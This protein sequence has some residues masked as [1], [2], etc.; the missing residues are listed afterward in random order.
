MPS[1]FRTT[2][3]NP[4]FFR[5]IK[6]FINLMKDEL[7][8]GKP[9]KSRFS[10]VLDETRYL[11]FE[12]VSKLRESCE[13]A[14]GSALKKKQIIPVR[15]WF[16][17]ELGLFTGL[18][19][20]EMVNLQ[21]ADLHIQEEQSSLTVQAGKGDKPRTVYFSEAFKHECLFYLE[22]KE[23]HIPGIYLFANR[24]GKQLSKRTLQ[25]SFKK[26]LGL[27]GLESHYSIH[28]LRHTY[29]SHLYKASGHN[30]RLVQE[31]LGHSSIRTTQIYASLMDEEVK[32]SLEELYRE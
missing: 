19:V 13:K 5:R 30:L 24:E 6:K 1:K 26:C 32:K 17:V 3:H 9:K 21:S 16:M 11:N 2:P 15:N 20:C 28:S 18:R 22:W 12:K 10:W 7:F 25:K 31:Q 8:P 23:K 29:G 4:T 27:A 14:R